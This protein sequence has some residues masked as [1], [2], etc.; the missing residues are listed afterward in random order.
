[1]KKFTGILVAVAFF[2]GCAATGPKYTEQL[3]HLPVVKENSARIFVFRTGEFAQ[4]SARAA[5]VKLDGTS[6]G[7]CEYKGFNIFDVPASTHTLTVD[8][9]DSP[10]SCSLKIEVDQHNEYYFEIKPRSGNLMGAL[11]GGL[12]GAAAE[13]AGKECGGAFMIEPVTPDIA[14][15]KLIDLSLSK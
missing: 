7:K 1:M 4:Y 8:M 6:I 9:W 2:S 10:G 14:K 15:T 11:F 5:S 3:S 12:V 13:S